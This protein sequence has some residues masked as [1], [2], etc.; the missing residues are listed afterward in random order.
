[1]TA[2]QIQGELVRRIA[3]ATQ[4]RIAACMGMHAST[5]SRMVSEDLEKFSQLLAALGLQLAP[6]DAVVVSQADIDA[7]E[8]MAFKYLQAREQDKRRG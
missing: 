2:A 1:M 6:D 3:Q 8:R 7:L 4:T 5:V